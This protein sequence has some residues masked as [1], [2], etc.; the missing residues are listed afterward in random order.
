MASARRAE[1]TG[2]IGSVILAGSNAEKPAKPSLVRKP[3]AAASLAKPRASQAIPSA[4]VTST[5]RRRIRDGRS[6][7]VRSQTL[8]ESPR[9]SRQVN[10][11]ERICGRIWTCS[12]PSTKV[13]APPKWSQKLSSWR[14]ISC[15]ISTSGSSL[16]A[17]GQDQL[18]NL[19]QASRWREGWHVPERAS[20][21]EV[22]V[23]PDVGL[24]LEV[25]KRAGALGP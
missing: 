7:L 24:V 9:C 12:C 21:G 19:R 25:L 16:E 20:Q 15:A 10:R 18:A 5:P 17:R 11:T 3:R 6:K 14:E 8:P 23:K 1:I 2:E 22:E 4:L 13:G